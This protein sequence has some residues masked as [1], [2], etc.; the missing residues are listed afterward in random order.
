MMF[1]ALTTTNAKFGALIFVCLVLSQPAFAQSTAPSQS[2][3]PSVTETGSSLE[4]GVARPGTTGQ[5]VVPLAPTNAQ[6]LTTN[7]QVNGA[8]PVSTAGTV[9]PRVTVP[10]LSIPALTGVNGASVVRS[11]A[12]QSTSPSLDVGGRIDV[13]AASQNAA[14]SAAITACSSGS[15]SVCSDAL[16]ALVTATLALNSGSTPA[17]A[18]NNLL[19]SLRQVVASVSSSPDA[20]VGR[21]INI[22]T[23][24]AAFARAFPESTGARPSNPQA[25]DPQRTMGFGFTANSNAPGPAVPNSSGSQLQPSPAFSGSTA[26]QSTSPK[27]EVGGRGD[28]V[29]ALM[30]IQSQAEFVAILACSSGTQAACDNALRALAA[31]TVRLYPNATPAVA[32]NYVLVKFREVI[33]AV[34]TSGRVAGSPTI[35]IATVDAAFGRLYPESIAIRPSSPS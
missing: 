1:S 28:I 33:A 25:T 26:Q 32:Q 17:V 31:A 2:S 20:T 14:M 3:L 16:G 10:G 7:S 15:Q 29:E 6:G 21:A 23:I 24:D 4:F 8:Q 13:L 30:G 9:Q 18:Q 12:P 22:A 11:T 35:N 19:I 5:S 27:F 34:R